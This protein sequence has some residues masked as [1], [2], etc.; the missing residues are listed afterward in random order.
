LLDGVLRYF[1]P[2]ALLA[3]MARLPPA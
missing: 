2:A 3:T 1:P